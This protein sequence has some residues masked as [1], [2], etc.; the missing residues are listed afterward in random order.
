MW[1]CFTCTWEGD[2]G[3][4]RTGRIRHGYAVEEAK[5]RK[6]SK[7]WKYQG[8]EGAYFEAKA[9]DCC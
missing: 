4:G 7:E 8:S 2:Q 5:A 6:W 9:R 1:G 3:S